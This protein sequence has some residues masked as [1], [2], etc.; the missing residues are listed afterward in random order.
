MLINRLAI[1][2]AGLGLVLQFGLSAAPAA[3]EFKA[4]TVSVY[5]PSG[6]GGGYDGYGRLVSRHLGRYL[7]GNPV[8]V[9]KNM[10]GAGGVVVGD[11]CR[12]QSPGRQR[13]RAV[14]GGRAVRAVVRQFPGEL[15]SAPV[16]L[17]HEPQSARQYRASSGT[18]PRSTRRRIF[19]RARC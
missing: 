17:D 19:S 1:V 7:P 16:Q 15:R 13:D 10:P 8:M 6:I 12:A 9:P 11:V 5:I 4:T 14:H 18:R 3:A 2:L